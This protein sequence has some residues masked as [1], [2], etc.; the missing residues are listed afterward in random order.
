MTYIKWLKKQ[1]YIP[2]EG[3]VHMFIKSRNL[4]LLLLFVYEMSEI[5]I[6]SL[7]TTFTQQNLYL[8]ILVFFLTE[9]ISLYSKQGADGTQRE[10]NN[11]LFLCI[12]PL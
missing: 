4:S 3:C 8:H 9:N 10:R 6:L 1:S 12:T 11:M 7:N 2:Y 5:L